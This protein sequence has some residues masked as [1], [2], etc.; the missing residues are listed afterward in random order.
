MLSIQGQA[1]TNE[2][3]GSAIGA[4]FDPGGIGVGGISETVQN[5]AQ[6]AVL[7][8]QKV[9]PQFI[10][11]MSNKYRIDLY[12]MPLVT[13]VANVEIAKINQYADKIR[14]NTT[15]RNNLLAVI[16]NLEEIQENM[17]YLVAQN[18]AGNLTL[19][20]ANAQGKILINTFYNVVGSM[21]TAEDLEDLQSFGELAKSQIG[22]IDGLTEMCEDQKQDA[23]YTGQ[24]RQ[25]WYTSA[26]TG[27]SPSSIPDDRGHFIS[28]QQ[29]LDYGQNDA[30]VIIS[31]IFGILNG[32]MSG[33]T[34]LQTL[35]SGFGSGT[36]W[37]E[38]LI[39]QGGFEYYP[40]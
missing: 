12:N 40:L 19:E 4:I 34:V 9:T 27:A 24:T 11:M 1:Q 25:K 16:A 23:G 13:P 36:Q 26:I 33:Y 29:T 2:D 18:N 14:E 21:I 39:W 10:Q 32:D 20:Q 6:K 35:Y 30:G 28:P 17:N 38:D 37:F 22:Y 5:N 31:Q 15:K 8:L 3:I 7:A